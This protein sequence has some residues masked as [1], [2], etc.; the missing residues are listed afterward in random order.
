MVSGRE[1]APAFAKPASFVLIAAGDLGV[2]SFFSYWA[3]LLYSLLPAALMR[4][5]VRWA[6]FLF[7]FYFIFFM[8][9]SVHMC[10]VYLSS[11]HSE[12]VLVVFVHSSGRGR[13]L[14]RLLGRPM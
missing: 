13:Q 6:A 5:R 8:H 14:L 4:S 2:V 12:L 3:F 9:C 11:S 1:V 10:L 7:F